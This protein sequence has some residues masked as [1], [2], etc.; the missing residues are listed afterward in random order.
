VPVNKVISAQSRPC[1]PAS[2]GPMARANRKRIRTA[3]LRNRDKRDQLPAIG[4]ELT[5][6][7]SDS[8]V[9]LSQDPAKAR[10]FL[11]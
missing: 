7:G 6:S 9:P 8:A 4:P 2:D 1:K 11:A 5:V 10:E 3:K